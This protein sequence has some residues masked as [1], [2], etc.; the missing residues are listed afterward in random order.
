MP[1]V[2]NLEGI[3]GGW[4]SDIDYIRDHLRR[5][6]GEDVMVNVASPGGLISEGLNIY[7]ALNNYSGTV[8]TN[9]AGVVASMAT[10]IFMVGKKRTAEKNAVFMIHN[11][12]GFAEGD[13]IEMFKFGSH[14][15][16]L[17]G[18]VAK[19][20]SEKTG[21]P[22]DDITKAMNRTTYYYG[23]EIKEAGFAHEMVGDEPKD[24]REE[25]VAFAELMY[26][27][28]QSKMNKPE[29][30]KKDLTALSVMMEDFEKQPSNNNQKPILKD[31]EETIMK[32]SE[33]KEKHPE[34]YDEV[35]AI[36]N[37]EGVKIGGDKERERVKM[38]TE[39]RAK[40]PKA[41]SQKVIDQAIAEG[42]DLN[43]LTLNLMAA[44]Q[45]ADELA[46]GKKDDAK[47]PA[48]G[49]G[50]DD[51]PEMKNGKM[52]H[53]GHIDTVSNQLANMP[54]VL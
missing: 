25:A 3:I 11:G 18:M 20:Y 44:D 5:A 10:Y 42:H 47:A 46:K 54:G 17:S 4:D 37:G 27:D 24:S 28:C 23:D 12:R 14:L 1:Y 50:G 13:H 2:I 30:V 9:A 53:I 7:N 41:H 45:A 31:P 29:K 16:S 22:L 34:L 26:E 36:G 52:E 33:L 43:S 6:N 38:L 40:F 49:D 51:T 48:N 15:K 21:T 39:M 19:E 35:V 8:D 32:L